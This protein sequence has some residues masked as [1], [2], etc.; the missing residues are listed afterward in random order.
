MIAFHAL[1]TWL[2]ESSMKT[3]DFVDAFEPAMDGLGATKSS[4]PEHDLEIV[5]PEYYTPVAGAPVYVPA[6]FN[7]AQPRSL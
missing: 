5:L 3:E 7:T 2:S 1:L 6:S 4:A